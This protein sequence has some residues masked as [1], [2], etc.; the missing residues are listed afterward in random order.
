MVKCKTKIAWMLSLVLVVVAV[1]ANVQITKADTNPPESGGPSD[2]I[3]LDF[4]DGTVNGNDVTYT[5]G[6]IGRA[7]V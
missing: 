1:F 2:T 5:V 3:T 7:H 4:S 6:E